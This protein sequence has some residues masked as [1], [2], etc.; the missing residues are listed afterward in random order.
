MDLHDVGTQP[1]D[2]SPHRR[3]GEQ[4][5]QNFGARDTAGTAPQH[6]H[7]GTRRAQAGGQL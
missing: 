4:R 1:P 6:F 2:S 5:E 7:F 3:H